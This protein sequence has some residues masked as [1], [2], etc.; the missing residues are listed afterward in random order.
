MILQKKLVDVKFNI[1]FR[2]IEKPTNSL[3]VPGQAMNL[4]LAMEQYKKGTLIEKVKGYYEREGFEAPDFN[5]MSRIEQL[6]A[7]SEFRHEKASAAKRLDDAYDK[8]NQ[9]YNEDVK[10]S[11]KAVQK[12]EQQQHGGGSTDKSEPPK[13]S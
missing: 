7:L 13:P 9:K 3:A 12:D 1:N 5:M 10:R 8:A 11:K 4:K 6:H 2:L